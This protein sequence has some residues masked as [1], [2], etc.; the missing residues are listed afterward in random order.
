MDKEVL[1]F[2]F[3]TDSKESLLPFV[4]EELPKIL[5]KPFES[6]IE[7]LH[8]LERRTRIAKDDKANCAVCVEIVNLCI[9]EKRWT[10]LGINATILAKRRGYSRNSISKVVQISMEAIET[11][12]D[13]DT[14][15]SLVK[16]LRDVTE[17]KIFIEVERARLTNILVEY[18]ESQGQLQE[19]MEL[20]QDLRLEILTTM[21]EKER[22]RMMLHQFKLC[23]ECKDQ[24][25]ASLCA[26]KITDQ[27][28]TDKELKL[29]FLE[30]L[31]EYYTDFTKDYLEMAKSYYDIYQLNNKRSNEL[32][33]AII[34][35]VLAPH[36]PEQL[37]FFNEISNIKDL[38]LMP[39][40]KNL[41]S[42]FMCNE[43]VPWPTFESRFGQFIEEQRTEDM[44]C[45]V[46]EHGLHVIA[47]YYTE[48]RLVR[49]AQLLQ[50]SVDELEK[51][52]IDLVFN[53][54]FYAKINRPKGII[55]FKRQQKVSEVA[56][57]FSDDIMKLCRLV[58]QA[59]SLIEKEHQFIHQSKLQ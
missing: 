5:E 28:L 37:R 24:L 46:I 29:E 20:L 17:G 4:E 2:E 58:D 52:I 21:E 22:I 10:D 45:R 42:V 14:K 31:I 3:M 32:M 23:L 39:E 40:A 19:A 26:E 6:A 35:A 43:L 16:V 8:A 18:M 55:T 33:K 49:L 36:S 34:N 1:T 56:D 54:D 59:H 27:K 57:E 51:R 41:L 11:I 12:T 9:K 48:I 47:M 7:G 25:R 15:I 50:L 30:L 13:I 53:E 38:A 44:R